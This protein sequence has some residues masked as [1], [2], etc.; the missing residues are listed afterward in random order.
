MYFIVKKLIINENP[1]KPV[2]N[3]QKTLTLNL[4]VIEYKMVRLKICIIVAKI[5]FVDL[6]YNESKLLKCYNF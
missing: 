4:Y 3:C 6:L 1:S 5:G 2:S